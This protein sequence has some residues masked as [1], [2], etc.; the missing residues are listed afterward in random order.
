V[1][2]AVWQRCLALPRDIQLSSC[3]WH[4]FRDAYNIARREFFT[5]VANK[6]RAGVDLGDRALE[7]TDPPLGG[8]F[9][10]RE[11]DPKQT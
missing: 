1:W 5:E 10:L 7:M 9:I 4:E 2:S 3:R 6:I 11:F 8:T